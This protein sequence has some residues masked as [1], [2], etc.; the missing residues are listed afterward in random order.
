MIGREL[1]D[2]ITPCLLLDLEA[3]EANMKAAT[4]YLHTRGKTLRP[5]FK[6]H[7]SVTLAEWQIERGASGITCARLDEAEALLRAGIE[8]VLVA[9]TFAGRPKCR[10]A[11][12]IAAGGRLI[13][14]LDNTETAAALSREAVSAGSVCRYVI[15]ID[16]GM[17]RAG[18]AT[19][20]AAL[21]LY[22]KSAELPNLEFAGLMGYEGHLVARPEG[23]EKAAAIKASLG[24]LSD[25][26]HL[27]KDNGIK[28]PL[29]SSGGTGSYKATADVPE[30]TELQMGTF[31]FMD[32]HFAGVGVTPFLPAAGVLARVVYRNGARVVLDCGMKGMH[33][34]HMPSV[35]GD[36]NLRVER[37]NAEHAVCTA[38]PGAGD[39]AVGNPVRL[40]LSYADGTLNLYSRI[41]GI[42][43]GRVERVFSCLDRL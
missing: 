29:V 23:P 7:R 30:V 32:D 6:V 20:Q 36:P 33:P 8:D 15:D 4:D 21:D 35:S 25:A 2:L 13:Y 1:N 19:P 28:V 24:K 42:R 18:T 3:A 41:L 40:N 12:E 5:H 11:A 38:L 22:R 14:V 10:K 31:M 27:F 26:V 34:L 9:N 43:D 39:Y 17:D 37:L 16:L